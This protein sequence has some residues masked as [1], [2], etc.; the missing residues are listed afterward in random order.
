[1][2][3]EEIYVAHFLLANGYAFMA[4]DDNGQLWA[5]TTVP[6]KFGKEWFPAG[7]RALHIPIHEGKVEFADVSSENY[8]RVFDLL[9]RKPVA[10]YT[11]EEKEVAEQLLKDGFHWIARN[12]DNK[13]YAYVYKPVKYA[14]RW[15]K[16]K[17]NMQYLGYEDKFKSI[18][19]RDNF[20]TNVDKILRG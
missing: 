20:P 14:H 9:N 3:D 7:K 17:G 4:R 1:M 5:F 13:L 11:G 16:C 8:E 15:N 6:H 12:E 19:W 2:T 18:E 10:E